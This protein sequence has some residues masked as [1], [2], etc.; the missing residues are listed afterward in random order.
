MNTSSPRFIRRKPPFTKL[1]MIAGKAIADNRSGQKIEPL[2]WRQMEGPH[3]F[4]YYQMG[5]AALDAAFS[6]MGVI[7]KFL[8]WYYG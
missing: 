6:Q 8:R 3:Q 5:K 4:G 1:E 7:G 2:M